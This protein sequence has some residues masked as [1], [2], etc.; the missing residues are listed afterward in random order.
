[1]KELS[2]DEIKKISFDILLFI[3]DYC[4][5]KDITYFLCG[6]TM[7][8]AFRHKGFIPWDDDID[9]ML[10]RDD[11]ERFISEFPCSGHYELLNSRNTHNFPYPFTKVSDKRTYKVES[12]RT[13]FSGKIGV[14]VDVFP[15][16]RVP[17]NEVEIEAYYGEIKKMGEQLL[18]A[19]CRFGRGKSLKSTVLRNAGI[20]LYR[21]KELLGLSSVER[22]IAEFDALAKKYSETNTSKCGITS[23]YHYGSKEV[24][25]IKDYFPILYAP[26]EGRLFP[27]PSNYDVYLRKLYGNY[28]ELPPLVFQRS[29]HSYIAYQ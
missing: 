22:I 1:M 15:I 5:S 20:L 13:R 16:D 28:M 17:E 23:I 26:F 21:V 25:T 14:D 9:I 8:G 12:I 3:D 6:G 24:N 4:K 7:L 27:I 18:C 10:F 29:H 11:Y 19:T 2:S